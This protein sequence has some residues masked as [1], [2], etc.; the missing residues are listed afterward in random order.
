VGAVGRKSKAACATMC[1]AQATELALGRTILRIGT[2]L[3][4]LISAQWP[5]VPIVW[6]ARQRKTQFVRSI[7]TLNSRARLAREVCFF[8]CHPCFGKGAG[9]ALGSALFAQPRS[10]GSLA[11]ARS[12]PRTSD[13]RHLSE[14]SS[15]S[16]RS[17]SCRGAKLPSIAGHPLRSRGQASSAPPSARPAPLP[18]PTEARTPHPPNHHP[19]NQRRPRTP[20]PLHAILR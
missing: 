3:R 12:A 16:E 15:R 2:M 1:I 4:A 8:A 11:R 13:S 6:L 10:A 14:R 18:A 5:I 7:H 9:R 17:E 19:T 20:Q